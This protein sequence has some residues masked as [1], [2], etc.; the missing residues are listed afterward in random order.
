MKF[1]LTTLCAFLASATALH[2][3][4]NFDALNIA[5][6]MALPDNADK[7]IKASDTSATVEG[8]GRAGPAGVT[9]KR[10]LVPLKL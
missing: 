2:A 10:R 8:T 3:E 1:L 9:S 5:S 4:C 7:T 6:E